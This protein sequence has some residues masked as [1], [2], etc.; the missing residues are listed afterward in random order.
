MKTPHAAAAFHGQGWQ[1]RT[2]SLQQE[3][4]NGL[5]WSTCQVNSEWNRLK[6]VAL[7]LPDPHTSSPEDVDSV[8][9]LEP[10]RYA[11]LRQQMN[12][13]GQCYQRL[14]ITVHYLTLLPAFAE[15]APQL[16]LYNLI[17]MRDLFFMTPMGAILARMASRVRAGEERHAANALTRLSIPILR[18][19]SGVGT[20]EGADALWVRPNLV[21]VG[22][23]KRTNELGFQQVQASLQEL[24]VLCV[25]VALPATIQHLLGILQIVDRD[26]AV[27]RGEL[28]SPASKGALQQAG[29]QLIELAETPEVTERYAMNL[30]TIAPRTVI[31]AAGN[32]ETKWALEQHGIEVAAE[33]DVSELLKGAGGIGCATGIVA[34]EVI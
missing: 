3:V 29:L 26:L 13:M 6:A 15:A 18:T 19:V 23:G 30:L 25:K 7:Y 34:R 32:S 24:G 31:M 12:A 11:V 8:Q 9:H 5:L 2:A 16:P 28:L 20:F 10:I 14:G 17:Y 4:A 21:F 33:L 27:V 1:P 22:V